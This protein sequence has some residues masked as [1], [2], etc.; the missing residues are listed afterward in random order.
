M[1][2]NARSDEF[3][4]SSGHSP[5]VEDALFAQLLAETRAEPQRPE[6]WD[7]LEARAADLQRPDEVSELFVAVVEEAIPSALAVS[8]GERAARFH[9][10]WFGDDAPALVR[11]LTR[12][13]E[14]EPTATF[15]LERLAVIHTAASRFTELLDL[16]DRAVAA[17]PTPARRVELLD[18]AANVAKDFAADADRAIGYLQQL[19][20]AR[21][22]DAQIFASLERLLE[23]QERFVE[24][25][26]AW[27]A[28]IDAG[29]GADEA[30][31]LRARIAGCFL[32]RLR[33]PAAALTEIRLLLDAGEEG[34]ALP[35]LE[36]VLGAEEASAE[37]RERALTLLRSRYDEQGRAADVIR[38]LEAT[39]ARAAAAEERTLRR[40]LGARLK[41]TGA[42]E[43]AMA[44]LAL[45]ALAPDDAAA[46]PELHALADATGAHARLA[47]G[48]VTAADAAAQPARQIALLTAAAELR[49]EKLRDLDG[50]ALLYG[51]VLTVAGEDTQAALPAARRLAT[52]FARAGR[53][54]ERLDALDRLAA[55]EPAAGARRDALAELAA[56]SL[57]LG[58]TERALDAHARRFDCAADADLAVDA[59]DRRT[60]S[61]RR[62]RGLRAGTPRRPHA[63]RADPGRRARRRGR[64]HR[65]VDEPRGGPRRRRDR[66]RRARR[67]VRAGGAQ[68]GARGAARARGNA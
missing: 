12:V 46:E 7:A 41:A 53:A 9:A 10:E 38:V 16:Y 52:L 68:R 27:Q 43:G 11:V 26:R 55:L 59:R 39:L 24:L 57:A 42:L 66:R 30:A 48:L 33:D 45:L 58:D 67:A 63:H 37:V 44:Q 3:P 32:E 18:E 17:A 29:V 8:L 2:K 15:P 20:A 31:T 65:D 4:E 14:L 5:A 54:R 19:A 28:R 1:D 40:E 60:A 56:E 51:R 21:P 64:G 61:T 62:V 6:R 47:E 25:I 36:R 35:L 50:A 49:A 22:L 34:H 23:R 13:L